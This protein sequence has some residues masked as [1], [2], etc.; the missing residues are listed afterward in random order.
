VNQGNSGGP[1][2]N[3]SGG[4]VGVNT[5]IFSPS[6]GNVGIAFAIPASLAKSVVESLIENGAVVRGWMGVSIQ[7]VTPQI[8]ESLGLEEEQS[9]AFINDATAGQPA[10][11]AG[12]QA[13]DVVIAID[14]KRIASPR[15][16]ARTVAEQEPGKNIEVT[17]WRNGR[18]EDISVTVGRM[19]APDRTVA[20]APD[21][22]SDETTSFGMTVAS[23]RRRP[24]AGRYRCGARQ[25]GRRERHRAG[26]RDPRGQLAAGAERAGS[27]HC[28]RVCDQCR[29]RRR[30]RADRA[31][32]CQPLRRVA[33]WLI[34]LG[35]CALAF[36]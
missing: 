5:A 1:A 31:R 34:G 24:G 18:T 8:A 35:P 28:G 21:V 7:E 14:G 26:R 16:L 36:I 23:R 2:F 20:A 15:E 6:G 10:A 4:V 12:I 25:R 27:H 30:P 17:V 22:P 11:E 32:Q 9:G 19:P 29:A 13:G 33:D 3:L